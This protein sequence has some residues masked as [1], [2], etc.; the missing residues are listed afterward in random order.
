MKTWDKNDERNLIL[1]RGGKYWPSW[2]F[3]PIK[4]K[5]NRL[6]NKNLGFLYHDAVHSDGKVRVYHAYMFDMPGV[7]LSDIPTT[8]YDS[9]DAMLADGWVVD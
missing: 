3:L 4:R 6:E 7:K 2:P 9:V 5:D 1:Q 8:E